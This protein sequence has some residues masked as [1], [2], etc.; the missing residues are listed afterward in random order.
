[1]EA[2][3]RVMHARAVV[4]TVLV[5]GA[6][7]LSAAAQKKNDPQECPYCEGQIGL[8]ELGGVVSH[9]GFEFGRGTTADIDAL[10]AVNDIRWIET[11]HFQIGFALGPHKVKQDEKAKI[12]A[13]LT[14]LAET[15]PEVKPKTKI[16]DPW[17]RAHLYA[18]RVEECWDR[19]VEL[20]QI[21][22]SAFPDGDT[23][24]NMQGEYMGDG[25]YLG[26]KGK[27]ELLL[28][29][30][31]ASSMLYL[32]EQFGLIVRLSQRWNHMERDTISLTAHTGQGDLRDDGAL[33]GHVVFNLT[34]NLLDGYKHYSYELPVWIRE[35]L[36]HWME[37]DLDP[38]FNTFNS[39]EGAVAHMTRKDKWKPEVTKLVARGEALRMAE[40]VHLK[41]YGELELRHHYTTWSVVDWMIQTNPDGLACFVGELTGLVNDQGIADG[42]RMPDAHRDAVKECFG[43]SYA[44]LDAAWAEWVKLNY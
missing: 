37:R 17:L 14:K 12:R 7:A 15:F 24:W 13:E 41:G 39:A 22:E 9:G 8:M 4:G 35:G 1:V 25:P 28:L 11:E 43:L 20:M 26:M 29:P 40:L 10:L 2:E 44:Q 16:L 23:I 38:R 31:E 33:H 42:S 27:Y 34:I 3:D 19:F 30:S 21:D 6:L 18:Q 5:L 32:R 36:G